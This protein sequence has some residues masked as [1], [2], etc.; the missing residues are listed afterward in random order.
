[1]LKKPPGWPYLILVTVVAVLALD[2]ASV[3]I[4]YVAARWPRAA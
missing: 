2:W 3:P 4:W 1:M